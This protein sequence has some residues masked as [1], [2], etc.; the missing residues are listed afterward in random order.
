MEVFSPSGPSGP[1]ES[2]TASNLVG[3]A[4]TRR[5]VRGP[6]PA[7]DLGVDDSEREVLWVGLGLFSE[8]VL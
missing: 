6:L 8:S 2:P 1:R 5:G 3:C 7:G 4:P